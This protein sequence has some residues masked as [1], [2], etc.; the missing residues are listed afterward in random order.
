MRACHSLS[1]DGKN[2]VLLLEAGPKDTDIWIHVP[3]GYDKLFK[4]KSDG[5][6][7]HCLRAV[8]TL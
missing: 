3:L 2:S 4:A 5:Y 7:R 8:R 1:A 6:P